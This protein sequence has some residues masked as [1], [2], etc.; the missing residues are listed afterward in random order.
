MRNPGPET[1]RVSASELVN[2]TKRWPPQMAILEFI[3]S[4]DKCLLNAFQ[5]PEL[6]LS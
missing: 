2:P 3:S 6:V 5:E 4:F 1:T